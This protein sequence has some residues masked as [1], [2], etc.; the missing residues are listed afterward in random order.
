[1]RRIILSGLSSIIGA[2]GVAMLLLSVFLMG[3]N[4]ALAQTGGGCAANCSGDLCPQAPPC[5]QGLS[6]GNLPL[7]GCPPRCVCELEPVYEDSCICP[8]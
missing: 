6:C 3:D 1:M 7:K 2:L 4:P 5:G 8:G